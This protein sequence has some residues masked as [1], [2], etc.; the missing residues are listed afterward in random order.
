MNQLSIEG[1][2]YFS[3]NKVRIAGYKYKWEK[4]AIKRYL[5]WRDK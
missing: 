3:R 2:L 4:K 1:L 5:Y